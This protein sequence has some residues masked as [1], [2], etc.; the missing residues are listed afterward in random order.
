[1]RA[2]HVPMVSMAMGT[3]SC[4]LARGAY[5][6][7]FLVSAAAAAEPGSVEEPCRCEGARLS[8]QVASHRRHRPLAQGT[9]VSRPGAFLPHGLAP[10]AHAQPAP[11]RSAAR[12][13]IVE[14]VVAEMTTSATLARESVLAEVVNCR[15]A[16]ALVRRGAARRGA[17][18]RFS[19]NC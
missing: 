7:V 3:N 17:A 2:P 19:K 4:A 18:R 10:V 8:G 9:R 5:F 11:R 16:W 14:E 13:G 12:A 1:M 6:V 15:A